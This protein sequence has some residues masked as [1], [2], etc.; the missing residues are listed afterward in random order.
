M[1]QIIIPVSWVEYKKG[2]LVIDVP[3]N[4]NV[5]EI[6]EE[7]E[8]RGVDEVA[9]LNFCYP[10]ELKEN[11]SMTEYDNYKITNKQDIVIKE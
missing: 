10:V 11:V 3:D 1:K 4:V 7:V 5:E 2:N 6:I 9:F 8:T